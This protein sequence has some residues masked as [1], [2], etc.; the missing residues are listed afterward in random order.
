MPENF[1][2]GSGA[3]VRHAFLAKR[4]RMEDLGLAFDAKFLAKTSQGGT[5][6]DFNIVI[7]ENIAARLQGPSDASKN[8]IGLKRMVKAIDGDGGIKGVIRH[9]QFFSERSIAYR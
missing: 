2:S 5:R 4:V 9:R 8:A 6:R 7:Q 1:K 3:G